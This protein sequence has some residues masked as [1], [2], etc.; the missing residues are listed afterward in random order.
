MLR[1]HFSLSASVRESGLFVSTVDS[2]AVSAMVL[3]NLLGDCMGF[4]RMGGVGRR[5]KLTGGWMLKE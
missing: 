1:V 2:D 4:C 5:R 3:Q